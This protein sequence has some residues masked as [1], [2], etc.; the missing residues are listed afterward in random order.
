[1]FE[2]HVDD[3]LTEQLFLGGAAPPRGHRFDSHP[4]LRSEPVAVGNLDVHHP[5]TLPM[6][7]HSSGRP[8]EQVS[9]S[10]WV[11]VAQLDPGAERGALPDRPV[12]LRVGVFQPQVQ[13]QRLREGGALNDDGA[14]PSGPTRSDRV[15]LAALDLVIT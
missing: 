13:Q 6:Q 8:G 1:M 14:E 3:R 2:R 9:R 15:A 4:I 5:V 11:R 7:Q 12:I 10:V